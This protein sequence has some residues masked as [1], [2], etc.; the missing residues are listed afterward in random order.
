MKLQLIYNRS[1]LRL[2][3]LIIWQI[4]W[5]GIPVFRM[6]IMS[7]HLKKITTMVH[8]SIDFYH[9]MLAKVERLKKE[10]MCPAQLQ[11]VPSHLQS[12]TKSCHL[13]E[14]RT[15]YLLLQIWLSNPHISWMSSFFSSPFLKGDSKHNVSAASIGC[16]CHSSSLQKQEMGGALLW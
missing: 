10:L 2:H 7:F 5:L 3:C 15:L 1:S 6:S 13:Q 11:W 9:P 14:I 16:G 4:L 12:N 8:M